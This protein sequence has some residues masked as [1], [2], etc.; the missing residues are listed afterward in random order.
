M[1]RRVETRGGGD[2][3]GLTRGQTLVYL[4]AVV[5]AALAARAWFSY[6]FVVRPGGVNF[7]DN[8]AW[9]HARVV[10]N[11]AAHW[12]AR[13]AMDPYAIEGG[14]R[15]PLAPLLDITVSGAAVLLGLGHPSMHLVEIVSAWAPAILGALIVIPT[16]FT[17]RLLFDGRAGLLAAALVALL[18]GHLLERSRLGYLDHH[19]L[20]VLMS[21][22]CLWLLLRAFQQQ[23]TR[24]RA[25]S[26][27]LA[28]IALGGYLLT[29]TTGSYLVGILIV[30]IVAHQC[31]AAI[32][33]GGS[34]TP[35]L[36]LFA[37]ALTAL[38]IVLVFQDHTMYRFDFQVASLV[39]AAASSLGLETLRR[40]IHALHRP[41][42]L[43]PVAGGVL[44][45]LAF[46]IAG[47]MAPG[48][49]AGM[50]AEVA[51]VAPDTSAYTVVE[52]MPLTVYATAPWMH[53]GNPFLVFGTGLPLGALGIVLLAGRVFRRSSPALTL[54]FVWT[55]AVF[56]STLLRNRF[57]Y[58]LIPLLALLGGWVCTRAMTWVERRQRTRDL[59]IVAIGAFVFAP[60]VWPA[61]RQVTQDLGMSAAW[62]ET[63]AWLR[64]HTPEPFGDPG[65]YFANY[66]GGLKRPA[67]AVMAW[68]DYGYWI[69]RAGRRVPVSNPTQSGASLAGEYLMETDPARAA[70]TLD[71]L[72]ARYVVVDYQLPLRIVAPPQYVL[73]KFEDLAAWAGKPAS[74]YYE[75]M[76]VRDERG[77]L[78]P[79]L[80]FYPLY[81]QTMVNRLYQFGG[82]AVIPASASVMTYADRRAPDGRPF[83][84]ITDMRS[85][86]TFDA[87]NGYLQSL[88]PG[89]HRL[90]GT[91]PNE[92][93]IPLPDLPDYFREFAS[94]V[95]GPWPRSSAVYVF[96]FRQPSPR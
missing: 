70:R 69:M 24:E 21:T 71:A 51:R 11:L 23:T 96:Q 8:D 87:A 89:P 43:L 91:E 61:H 93:P 50:E 75:G 20:E 56:V 19:V 79:A 49:V 55:V 12:P 6:A 73:G 32:R 62:E 63:T 74:D 2:A 44:A 34:E 60:N 92:S 46:A 33:G 38:A 30:W 31:W 57:G 7:Q 27:M 53:I 3:R 45:L 85:F 48:L 39:I 28:G 77:T 80:V 4:A 67:Y 26:G 10:D 66:A 78:H 25:V 84:E 36:V 14:Q 59:V 41:A 18:P 17:G 54:L 1:A 52:A 82:R 86:P 81:Y 29:W 5:L 58:Y 47:R 68:W 72:H 95:P 88:G 42:W 35:A 40:V 13:F 64:T 15:V 94:P 22:T 9:Y 16:Y 37:A 65:Y 83:R 76:Y 90:V